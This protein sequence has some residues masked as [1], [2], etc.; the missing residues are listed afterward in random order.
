MARVLTYNLRSLRDDPAALA[1]VVRACA[2]DL[3]CLQEV[4]RYGRWRAAREGLAR[5]VGMRVLAGRRAAGL[6]VL[7]GPG[8]R[9]V[10]AG[11]HRL[12]WAP[13]RHRRA[14]AVA[15]V[16]VAGRELAVASVHLGLDPVERL[17]HVREL[18]GLLPAYRAPVVLGGDFNEGPDGRAW[19]VLSGVLRDAHA[20]APE[21]GAATFPA[22]RPGRRIDGFFT[23]PELPVLGCGVP[24]GP[25]GDLTRATD[26]LPV[27]LRLG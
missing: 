21:G 26:H 12:S 20:A 19:T 8:V 5:S 4:P 25:V 24:A 23:D 13:P 3:L 15:V 11:F 10:R 2:P 14:L 17:G 9:L 16:E 6:A 22:R 7:G 18:L 1:R 27:L